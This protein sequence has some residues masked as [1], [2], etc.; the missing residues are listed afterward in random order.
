M[1][2]QLSTANKIATPQILVVSR[3]P[4]TQSSF[5]DLLAGKPYRTEF[6]AN[7]SE[8]FAR[9]RRDPLPEL[10]FLEID[11]S[12]AALDTLRSLRTLDPEVKIVVIS[13]PHDIRQ[14]VEAIRLGAKDYLTTPMGGADIEQILCRHMNGSAA[15]HAFT[16][17]E[18]I[19]DVGDGQYFVAA[20]P[21]MNKIRVQLSVLAGIDVPVLILGES[22]TG[23]EIAARM[24]HKLSTRASSK[25]MKVN[26]A[27][28]P[29]ELLE[30]ELFGYERGA[31]TGAM[32]TKAGKFELCENGTILLDEIAEMPAHLQAKLLHVLQD[33]Q[34]F[35]LGGESQIEVDVRILAATNVDVGR[36][37]EERKLREDLYYRLSAFTVYLPPLRNRKNE[38]P[39]LMRHFMARMAAQ[40][41]RPPI[42]FTRS[43]MDACLNY[44]WPG[45]LRELENFVKRYLVMGEEAAAIAELRN[46]SNKRVPVMNN[47]FADAHERSEPAR[48]NGNGFSRNLKSMVRNL[49]DEAEIQAITQALQETRWN[50]KRAARLLNISYRGLLYKIRQYGITR[51]NGTELPPYMENGSYGR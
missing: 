42:A 24:I 33:K 16:G 22:G 40:Y 39:A 50:R 25:L 32:R 17:G 49:K 21:L 44:S 19:D 5:A 51:A 6:I 29:G 35:R 46:D 8:A 36:A 31:F 45:N 1:L 9:L 18:H 2:D 10:V 23:K 20:G 7:P 47:G 30:S 27:A 28:L 37:M 14:I 38:I 4:A 43:L 15:E 12:D 41:S 3:N 48:D 34:F 11:L 26:C 13:I